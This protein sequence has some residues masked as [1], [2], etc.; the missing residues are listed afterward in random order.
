MGR[1][2]SLVREDAA[3]A[4]RAAILSHA[5]ELFLR[6]GYA[7]VTVSEIAGAARV[8]TQTI[9]SSVGGKA[10]IFAELLQPAIRDPLSQQVNANARE[11]DDPRQVVAMVA[12]GTRQAHEQYWDILYHLIRTAPGDA[13]SQ[14]AIGTAVEKCLRGLRGIAERLAELDA[15]Q[16]DVHQAIDTLWFYFGQ[17]AWFSLVGDRGWSFDRAEAWLLEAACRELLAVPPPRN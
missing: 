14:Q 5:R 11:T 12:A 10:A 16:E 7:D 1:Y 15:L 13:A 6:R 2:R 8:A 17:N 4:T 9:Y 3:N